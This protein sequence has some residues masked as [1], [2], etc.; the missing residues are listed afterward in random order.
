M[1]EN[2]ILHYIKSE[3][4]SEFLYLIAVAC[5]ERLMK[6]NKYGVIKAIIDAGTNSLYELVKNNK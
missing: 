6:M 2:Q 5:I 4:N 1:S 3:N